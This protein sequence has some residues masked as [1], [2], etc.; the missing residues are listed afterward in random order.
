MN[1]ASTIA[2]PR[3][4][5]IRLALGILAGM[6]AVITFHQSTLALMTAVGALSSNVYSMRRVPP[7]GVPQ[8]VSNTFWGGVWGIVFAAIAPR[9][10]GVNY[11][12]VAVALGAVALPAAAW[13]IVAPLKGQPIASGWVPGRMA[14]SML[15]NGAWGVGVGVI[16]AL[17]TLRSAA[18]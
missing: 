17:L 10:R 8:I 12:L 5:G 2:A 7:L 14:L 1:D 18:R 9:T 6:L 13:F 4:Y 11:W 15:I 3:S 16:F